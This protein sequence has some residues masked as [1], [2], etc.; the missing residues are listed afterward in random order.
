METQIYDKVINC[1][2]CLARW[3]DLQK[4]KVR[5]EDWDEIHWAKSLTAIKHLRTRI[6]VTTQ[7]Y[8]SAE[9]Q[10]KANLLWKLRSLQKRMLFSY[11]NLIWA[12]RRVTQINKGKNTPGLDNFFVKTKEDRFRLV[13]LVRHHINIMQWQPAPVKRTHILKANGK[14][15][16]LGISTIVD[17]IIQAIYKNA[18]EPE[19]ESKADIGSYG[20]RPGRSAHD[21][22]EK[23][24]TTIKTKNFTLPR[25]T[26]ILEA[27]IKG[28]FENINHQYLLTKIGCFP[29]NKLI[30]RWLIAGYVDKNV[31][32][33]TD[34]GTPQGGIISPLLAN[35]A[36]D[37]LENEINIK[38]PLRG[39]FG[40]SPKYKTKST[41]KPPFF[42]LTLNDYLPKKAP[43]GRRAYVRYADDFVVLCESEEDTT[44]AKE[45]VGTA[46]KTR[47]LT[48]SLD[49]TKI[50]HIL[51]GFDFLGV[52]IRSYKCKINDKPNKCQI[53]GYKPLIK[54]S[55]KSIQKIKDKIR[56]IFLEAKGKPT[57][58]LIPEINPVIRGWGNYFRHYVSRRVFEQLDAY[59]FTRSFRYAQRTHPQ[60]GKKWV[61][62]RYFGAFN[63]SKP[64][65]NWVFANPQVKD[66]KRANQY[67]LKFRW[68]PIDRHHMVPNGYCTDDP[69]L[70]DFWTDRT[71]SGIDCDI[72]TPGDFKIARNQ[73]H[74]CPM[75][76][77]SL[78]NGEA[79]EKHHIGPPLRGGASLPKKQGGTN[80]YD[81]LVFLH[82]VCHQQIPSFRNTEERI[83]EIRENLQEIQK[84]K[85][86]NV[87]KVT[88]KRRKK[89][90]ANPVRQP[91]PSF[92]KP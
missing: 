71:T 51:A 43:F 45:E 88:I 8:D 5:P 89:K 87:S 65:D 50:T 91:N 37:G 86:K 33:H 54:P 35:I 21:A 1:E 66:A 11:D 31:F 56:I 46:L 60:K 10:D 24:F 64:K 41:K 59:L 53:I 47:G 30:H 14:L 9:P 69:A 25:K 81:N 70:R 90:L 44:K 26:W 32:H 2:G 13:L 39:N 82:K 6:F 61:A 62:R 27:D 52:N 84:R 77:A 12:V 80:T 83:T 40:R 79:I 68:I 36:L 75:C 58:F 34:R 63:K 85:V 38:S 20:F 16:P 48:F 72:V 23:V 22:I 76:W 49:K 18:L 19:W 57:T 78:Y 29:G 67:M 92:E 74:I 73:R 55:K 15:R 28:C 7:R 42:R 3:N 17:R 4:Q